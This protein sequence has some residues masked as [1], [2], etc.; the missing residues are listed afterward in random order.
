VS[1]LV[2]LVFSAVLVCVAAVGLGLSWAD[3]HTR[4]RW[5][6]HDPNPVVTWL[7]GVVVVAADRDSEREET[8]LAGH[9]ISGD[10][11]RD[12]YQQLMADLAAEDAGAH[13]LI[14]PSDRDAW[15]G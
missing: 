6:D 8:G 4:R 7:P 5:A 11:R 15:P 13:P 14:V 12:C 9:L 2:L 1:D 3:W 10:L